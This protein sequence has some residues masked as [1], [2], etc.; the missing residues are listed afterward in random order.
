M[1]QDSDNASNPTP[2][3][4]TAPSIKP[5]A[6]RRLYDWVLLWAEHPQATWALFIIAFAEASFFPIPPDI[7]LLAMAMGAPARAMQFALVATAGSVLGGIA[8]YGMGWGLWGSMD[9]FFYTYIPG[10][11]AATFDLMAQQFA[12]NTFLTI[13]TAGFT[14]IPFKIFTVAAGAAAVPFILFVVGAIISR[15]LRF[16]ILAGL[17]MWLGPAVKLWIDRY[18]NILTIAAT[19]ILILIV[20]VLRH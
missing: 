8:G 16:S 17:V 10:F 4:A 6:I 19:I 5:H 9:N 3:T 20:V 13:F 2:S 11:S 12:D 15:G 14:P 7:L 18:F 1:T